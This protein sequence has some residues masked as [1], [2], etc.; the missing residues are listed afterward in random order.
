MSDRFGLFQGVLADATTI[1]LAGAGLGA[2]LLAAGV[3]VLCA[4][5]GWVA[6]ALRRELVR[7]TVSWL[8]LIVVLALPVLAGPGWT[9]LG[10]GLLGVACYR[11]F[12]RA[13]GLFRERAVSLCVALGIVV[14]TLAVLESAYPIF[15]AVVPLGAALI[16]VASL[17]SDRPQGYIQRTALGLFAFLLFGPALGHLGYLANAADYRPVILL[18]LIA[19]GLND[20]FAFVVG[21][22]M[23]GRK[24]LPATSPGKTVA[25]GVGAVVLTT[26]AVAAMG[27]LAFAGTPMADWP[28]LA[29]LGVLVSVLGQAGDLMLSAIKRDLGLKDTGALIPGH[30]GL[31]DRFDSLLLVAPAAFYLVVLLGGVAFA[32]ARRWLVGG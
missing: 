4:A 32:P 3:I 28:A 24:L 25:G 14:T 31:L 10:V 20:V 29:A 23:G 22:A 27:R 26:A 1:V 6:P 12:A 5:A 11:E 13:T 21:K 2:W 15:V 19:V 18:L 7:R 8:A 9:A 30:G 17:P 16:A